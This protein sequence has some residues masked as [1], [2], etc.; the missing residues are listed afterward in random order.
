MKILSA[1]QIRAWDQATI[2]NKAIESIELMETA[3]QAF[4]SHLNLD[5]FK[6]VLVFC[7]SGN[8]GGDGLAIARILLNQCV[9]V[10]TFVLPY[11]KGS[12]DFELNLERLG[13]IKVPEILSPDVYL[14]TIASNDLIIDALFG[15][16]LNRPLTGIA[17]DLVHHI[18]RSGGTVISVD[19]ASGCYCD[20]PSKGQPF[21][22]AHKTISFQTPKL[23]FFMVDYPGDFEIVDIGLDQKFLANTVTQYSYTTKYEILSLYKEREKYSHKGTYGHTLLIAGSKGMMGAAVLAAKA[24]MR[25]GAGKLTVHLPSSGNFI[26]QSTF[27]EAMLSLDKDANCVS[28]LPSLNDY[29]VIAV[30]PGLGKEA[31]TVKVLKELLNTADCRLV[32]DADALNVIASHQLK[33]LI[34]KGSILTPHPG[35][36]KRL[37]GAWNDDL[38][39]WQLQ[40]QLAKELD[41]VIILKGAHTSIVD[42]SGDMYFNCSGNPGMATAGS[43]DVLT[44]IISGLVAQ[45]YD[46]MDA[47]RLGVYIHGAAGDVAKEK[48]GKNALIA[49]D[50]VENIGNI[51]EPIDRD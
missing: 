32:I 30:G 35:E 6:R 44:G 38:E 37:M 41:A 43:G 11:S 42:Y 5:H 16:G 48:F 24:V 19:I 7:G 13:E 36:F 47:A 14:P 26:L 1:A 20:Q 3:S 25:A 17:A 45:G 27:P 21:V 10:E 46:S 15:S 22:K 8:N 49:S 2:N 18:N 4:V 28:Q 29:N 33:D 50:I 51:T 34:P 23:A 31:C 12:P 39:K 9:Q 40:R